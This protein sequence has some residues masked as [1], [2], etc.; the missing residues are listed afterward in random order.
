MEFIRDGKMIGELNGDLFTRTVKSSVHLMVNKD[1][2]AIDYKLFDK[3]L[4]PINAKISFY[5]SE[6]GITYNT[7]A[8]TYLARGETGEYGSYGKQIFLSR[9]WFDKNDPNQLK[10]I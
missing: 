8:N 9:K 2:W 10:L 5:D 4:K 6:T 3:Y 7:D 1:A